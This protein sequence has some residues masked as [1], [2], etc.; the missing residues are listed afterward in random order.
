MCDSMNEK[1]SGAVLPARWLTAAGTASPALTCTVHAGL[2]L[3]TPEQ[4]AHNEIVRRVGTGELVRG[5]AMIRS[6]S[7]AYA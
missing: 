6:R 7:S 1:P 3:G 5:G 4:L 2:P